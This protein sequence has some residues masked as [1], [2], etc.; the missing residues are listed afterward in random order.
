MRA[1]TADSEGKIGTAGRAYVAGPMRRRPAFNFPAF[2]AAEEHLKAHGFEVFN[3]ARRDM[4]AKG[5]DPT[6]L[7]GDEDLT[8]LGF[9]LRDALATDLDWIARNAD[10]VVVL[11]GW[12]ESRGARAE[13]A[14]ARALGLPVETLAGDPVEEPKDTDPGWLCRQ[15]ANIVGGARRKAYGSAEDNFGRIAILWQAWSKVLKTLPVARMPAT[16]NVAVMNILQKLARIAETPDHTDSWR[17]I[18]GYSDCGARCAGADPT[19]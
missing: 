7:T 5:F 9:C 15:A 19:K 14:L 11:P 16:A 12:E 10:L 17:D 18:A 13:V 1:I 3:P 6:G 4:E 8:D 2:M